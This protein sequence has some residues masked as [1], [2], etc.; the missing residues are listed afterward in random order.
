MS[1]EVEDSGEKFITCLTTKEIKAK[2]R[3]EFEANPEKFYP[4]ETLK[5][6]GFSRAQCPKCNN[7]FWRHTPARE[8]C[9]DC[10][11][12]GSYQFIGK[13]TGKGRNGNKVT[14]A[15]AW[16]GFKRSLSSARIPCTAIDRYPVV[17]RWRSDVDFVA[18]GIFC[19]QPYCV[20]GELEPPANPLI[21]PQ[22]C[23]RFND[24]DN[25]GLTGRH[26]SGFIMLGIQVFNLPDK[27]VFF[28]EECVEFNL[29]WLIE[30]LEIDPD[31]ITLIEDVWAGGG[32]L[33][34][35]IE[36]FIGGLELGNMVFMQYKTFPDGSREELPVKVI[37]V[38]IGLERIPWL[39]NGTA[40]SYMEVFP[41]AFEYLRSRLSLE[42]NQEVWEKFGP[43]SCQLNVD[44]VD[45][46]DKTWAEIAEKIGMPV[47][48]VK[49]AIAP[50]RELYIICDHTRT[51]LMAIEDGSLP[52]NVGGASNIRNILRRV[53][54]LM[55]R[56]NW[57]DAVG[58]MEGFIQIFDKH[59]ED[60]AKIYGAF[61]EYKSFRSIIEVERE[62][63]E[64]TDEVQRQKLEKLVKKN[65][66]TLT[67]DDWI[68][69]M[70][71][72]GIPADAIADISGQPV[73]GNLYYEIATRQ[74]RTAKAAEVILYDTTHLP[75]TDMLYLK[76][77]RSLDFEGKIVSV[78]ANIQQGNANNIVVL[79][80]TAYY[81]TSGGQAHDIGTLTIAGTTYNVVD[82]QKVGRCVLHILDT[83]LPNSADSYLNMAIT[84]TIDN[85]R[86]TQL[87]CHH[88]STH[89]IFASCRK[90][91]GPHVWQ[92]GAKKTTEQAH[93]DITHYKSLSRDEE[94]AIEN[95][96]NRIISR[97]HDIRKYNMAKDEAEKAHGF[98]LYQGGVVPGNELRIVEIEGTDTEACCGTHCDNTAE[99]GWVRILRS[100]RIS[101]G[102]VRLYF[103][104]GE[105]AIARLNTESLVLQN[106][107][108]AWS[109]GMSDLV[110]T[111]E[112]FF[113]GYKKYGE[114]VKK[115]AQS[116]LELQLKCLLL[117][118]STKL[119]LIR[120]TESDPTI[121]IS[122]VPNFALKLKET[123]KAVVFLSNS[124]L[125]G[126]TGNGGLFDVKSL[127]PLCASEDGKK[128]G[129][130]IK[131]KVQNKTKKGG[132][133][134]VIPDVVEFQ[135]FNVSSSETILHHLLSLGF[136]EQ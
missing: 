11:C 131:D 38:G 78:M 18:A 40:T 70:T 44:E 33:G 133:A 12:V 50:I 97:C 126:M 25:I 80:R 85:D 15:Q 103:V 28:K 64:S 77:H 109:V 37:D 79:D 35:S 56:N 3:P 124:F 104:A 9:G 111:A 99:V 119:A 36:Y 71:S 83:P 115:Q 10:S 98:H 5:R 113:D 69:A 13:G 100:N 110:P 24:L 20:T 51:V 48:A 82:C 59:R 121:Y 22:F 91:L 105:K 16:E 84:G 118:P 123:N 61:K 41:S 87:R 26:Y 29:R 42:V 65:K 86:R 88:T 122:S 134:E 114:K 96:A 67:M 4:V 62:R 89:I 130:I 55:K 117:D 6:F 125:Y 1:N 68:I 128:K 90:V 73:P 27:F 136:V 108:D 135:C 52:S 46:L 75:P 39:I 43:L 74:E 45:D 19:F 66:G 57:W 53:F 95:E 58:G 17:A 93:L 49:K 94:L 129:L 23:L 127:E 47:D 106:L 132:K 81:P 54:A 72:W 14:Y 8:H 30:E 63:W 112:R 31:E 7:Y 107:S 60:L 92:H 21:C 102:I 76:D 101:D 116:I 32:N 120:S 34:P 2:A